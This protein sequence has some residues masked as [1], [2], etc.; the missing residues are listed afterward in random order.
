MPTPYCYFAKL[1]RVV[2]GDTADVTIDLG[3]HIW[4][5]QRVRIRGV[6]TP[7]M[8]GATK[9]A[10]EAAKSF[11]EDWFATMLEFQI[12]TYLDKTD[13]FGRVLADIQCG[14]VSLAMD[15]LSSGHAVPYKEKTHAG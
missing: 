2:D 11:T 6:D 15:L 9:A 10:G 14:Y 1:V 13:S 8:H 12:R 4:I 3:F 5:K 7:E